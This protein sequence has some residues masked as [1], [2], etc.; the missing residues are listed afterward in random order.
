MQLKTRPGNEKLSE[1]GKKKREKT[2]ILENE[3]NI[4][5][6]VKKYN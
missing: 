6:E 5:S 4:S 2:D 1:K 3:Q